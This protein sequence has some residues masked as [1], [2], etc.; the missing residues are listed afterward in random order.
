M[1]VSNEPGYY[2][3]NNFGIRIENLVYIKTNKKK[4]KSLIILQWLL[5]DKELIN[6]SL[7]SRKEKIG[8]TIIIKKFF[9]ILKEV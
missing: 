5:I 2:G 6:E 3:K 9:I 8:L 7:L 1:I 4:Q